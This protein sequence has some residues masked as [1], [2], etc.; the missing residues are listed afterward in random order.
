MK[1]SDLGG[2]PTNLNKALRVATVHVHAPGALAIVMATPFLKGSVFE[3]GTV[4][5]MCNG[6]VM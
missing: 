1:R 2:W 4:M 5:M 6:T 3:D